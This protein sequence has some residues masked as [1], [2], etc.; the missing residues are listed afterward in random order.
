M[1]AFQPQTHGVLSRKLQVA[2]KATFVRHL[3]SHIARHSYAH[4]T[5]RDLIRLLRLLK[6]SALGRD[7]P[8]PWTQD[9]SLRTLDGFSAQLR[10]QPRRQVADT[11]FWQGQS[12]H[13]L[14]YTGTAALS[15]QPAEVAMAMAGVSQHAAAVDRVVSSASQEVQERRPTLQRARSSMTQPALQASD[16]APTATEASAAV[17]A[18]DEADATAGATLAQAQWAH[19]ALYRVHRCAEKIE[20]GALQVCLLTAWPRSG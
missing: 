14:T 15:A 5:H 19:G 20:L 16:F 11:E 13:D 12:V 17:Q 8:K 10:G 18:G 6:D 3:V 1:Q 2:P 9:L 7:A 4:L